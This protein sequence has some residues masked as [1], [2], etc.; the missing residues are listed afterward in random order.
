MPIAWLA[1][2]IA[3]ALTYGLLR[4]RQCLVSCSKAPRPSY[5]ASVMWFA[6]TAGHTDAHG[7]WGMVESVSPWP[8]EPAWRLGRFPLHEDQAEDDVWA[9]S[10]ANDVTVRME[11]PW[12]EGRG[13]HVAS[14]CGQ[15][16][17]ACPPP[18]LHPRWQWYFPAP[19]PVRHLRQTMYSCPLCQQTAWARP[20]ARLRCGICQ[21]PMQASL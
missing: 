15:A 3:L 5:R 16:G 10:D 1:T 20:T 17:D 7:G 12:Q 6:D 14:R 9:N 21:R 8:V 19:Q 2:V 11:R 18:G 4:L 13:R